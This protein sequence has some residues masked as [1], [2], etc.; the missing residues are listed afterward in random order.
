[1]ILLLLLFLFI[2]LGFE[3]YSANEVHIFDTFIEDG[4]VYDNVANIVFYVQTTSKIATILCEF[5]T[6]PIHF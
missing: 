4:G 5:N 2:G 6:I 1:M 3:N